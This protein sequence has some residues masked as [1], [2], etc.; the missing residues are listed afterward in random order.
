[1]RGCEND[2][3]EHRACCADCQPTYDKIAAE[4]E[5]P[6]SSP[7]VRRDRV[8]DPSA[9]VDDFEDIRSRIRRSGADAVD[10]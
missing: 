10:A 2:R 7:I 6:V 3:Q 9:Y 8:T 4:L 1:M 5:L